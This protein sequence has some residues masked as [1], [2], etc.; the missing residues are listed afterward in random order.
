MSV[1]QSQNVPHNKKIQI[2]RNLRST[3]CRFKGDHLDF[4]QMALREMRNGIG[5]KVPWLFIESIV[6]NCNTITKTADISLYLHEILDGTRA[7]GNT[8]VVKMVEANG[9]MVFDIEWSPEIESFF[10]K[11]KQQKGTK[12]HTIVTKNHILQFCSMVF[13]LPLSI[14]KS[15]NYPKEWFIALLVL[16]AAYFND[17]FTTDRITDA[18]E[19]LKMMNR[20]KKVDLSETSNVVGA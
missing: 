10:V 12:T 4:D 7:I 19:S 11:E 16:Q 9:I 17:V 15:E 8:F 14:P 3:G 5:R 6:T 2:L 13:S 1:L 18:Q 20:K